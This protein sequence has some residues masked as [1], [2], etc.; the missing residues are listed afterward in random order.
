MTDQL[1]AGDVVN[2]INMTLGGRYMFEGKAT[3]TKIL[4]DG[5]AV[6][7]FQGSPDDAPVERYIDPMAQGN[8]QELASYIW[9][10]NCGKTQG[11]ELPRLFSDSVDLTAYLSHRGDVDFGAIMTPSGAER[12]AMEFQHLINQARAIEAFETAEEVSDDDPR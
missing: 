10:L 4:D 2:V 8:A 7:R 11:L 6:V 12:L 9:W 1:K 3:V 5:N